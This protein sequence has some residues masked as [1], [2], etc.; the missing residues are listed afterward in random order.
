MVARL[1]TTHAHNP[2]GLGLV[3]KLDLEHATAVL[4]AVHVSIC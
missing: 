3:D 1:V 4:C 2:L